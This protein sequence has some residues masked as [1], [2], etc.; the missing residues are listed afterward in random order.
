MRQIERRA[1][2]LYP[3]VF[4]SNIDAIWRLEERW[5][6]RKRELESIRGERLRVTYDFSDSYAHCFNR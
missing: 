3:R 2:A 4:R 5:H 1:L 6:K